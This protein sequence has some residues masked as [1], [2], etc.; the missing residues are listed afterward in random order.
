[1]TSLFIIVLNMS[2]TASYVALGVIAARILLNKSPRIFSYAL[3]LPV[4]I[5]LVLPFSF[6]SSISFFNMLK[7]DKGVGGMGMEYIPKDIGFM[8]K[9]SIDVGIT[10]LNNSVNTSLPIATPMMSANPMQILMDIYCF[11]WI[12]GIA[13]LL[14]Y[15][16]TSY[17]R[18]LNKI[19][20]ATLVKNNIFETD[21]IV[22]PFVCGFIRP[23]IYI[24]AGI[25]ERE[26]SYV[27]EHEQ[28]HIKRFDYIIKPVAFL[29]LIIHWFN[30]LMW[31]SFVLM[32][33]DMEMSCD[34]SVLGKLGNDIKGSYANSLLGLSVK[35]SGLLAGSPL[36]FG[37]SSIKS[38]IKN[39][40][41]FKKPAFWVTALSVVLI[42]WLIAGFTANPEGKNMQED[43]YYSGYNI[44]A[45]LRN[46]TL[47]VGDNS[48]VVNL[49]DAMQLPAGRSRG[50]V[51]LQTANRPYE[52]TININMKDASAIEKDGSKNEYYMVYNS[53]LLF[54][55]IDNVDKI[56]FAV[57]DTGNIG[58]GDYS[59]TFSRE[60]AEKLIG[61]EIRSYAANSDTIKS[62]IDKFRSMPLDVLQQAL[63]TREVDPGKT[64]NLT[65][66]NDDSNDNTIKKYITEFLT[67]GYSKYYIIN[68]IDIRIDE[69]KVNNS[70]LEAYILTTMNSNVLPKDPETVPY[71]QEAKLKAQRET[72]P[73]RKKVLH[74]EY[75]TLAKE[76][77]KPNDANFFFK[78]TAKQIN[79]RIAENT[80][81]LFHEQESSEGLIYVPADE[82]LPPN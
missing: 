39:I 45:L 9:P 75:E 73:E 56:H 28:A 29:V 15:S 6:I 12:A 17:I 37:E 81:A 80:I 16:V 69:I 20:T 10:E 72:N 62:L 36:A 78:L 58:V 4:L 74:H 8:V 24:P 53:I 43:G 77:G 32:S 48:K 11:I 42:A 40:L 18:L 61:G 67:K 13:A 25:S 76:Y 44:E 26:L 30:P 55:L 38:R 52:I 5:R 19:K 82:I 46:K 50:A 7:P 27:I 71:I 66:E 57:V 51:E 21:R 59:F 31:L 68:S 60:K 33:K 41:A 3:W 64:I 14:I 79:N 22:T 65:E 49:I 2:I 23:K 34:E 35:R 63:N 47:Y 70:D 54:A 1:M